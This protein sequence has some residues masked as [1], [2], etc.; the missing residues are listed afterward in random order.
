MVINPSNPDDAATVYRPI[1]GLT[2]F[3]DKLQEAERIEEREIP[4]V[5]GIQELHPEPDKTPSINN[6]PSYS[7]DDLY[8]DAYRPIYE[9]SDG[10]G[11]D[12]EPL[13][14]ER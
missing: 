11:M 3:E 4:V 12:I 1:E 8:R 13:E 6:A 9:P 2:K 7:A 10:R 5:H 14:I